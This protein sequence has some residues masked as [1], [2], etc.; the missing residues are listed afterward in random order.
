MKKIFTLLAL[1]A[2]AVNAWAQSA[3][4]RVANELR[5]VAVQD[6]TSRTISAPALN[7]GSVRPDAVTTVWSENF[8]VNPTSNGWQNLG[9]SGLNNTSVPDTFGVWEYRGSATTP[10]A[11]QGSRGA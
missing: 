6:P 3:Q 8:S 4:H 1:M 2:L 11:N 5:S 9:F 10:A 7:T